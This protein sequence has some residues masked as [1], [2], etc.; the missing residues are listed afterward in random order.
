MEELTSLGTKAAIS[1]KRL[2]VAGGQTGVAGGVVLAEA[3]ALGLLRAR[4]GGGSTATDGGLELR[5]GGLRGSI[6]G[7]VLVH[8]VVV[9]Q[10]EIHGFHV[11]SRHH[12]I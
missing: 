12:A 2:E 8:E 4:K 1:A 11:S 3:T 9:L 5:H 7:G 6:A 10:L